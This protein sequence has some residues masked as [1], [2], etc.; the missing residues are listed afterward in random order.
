MRHTYPTAPMTAHIM[1]TSFSSR[2]VRHSQALRRAQRHMQVL[3]LCRLVAAHC[4]SSWSLG[5]LGVVLGVAG[6]ALSGAQARKMTAN[7]CAKAASSSSTYVHGGGR[8]I[9]MFEAARTA[10]PTVAAH[11]SVLYRQVL[12]VYR[13]DLASMLVKCNPSTS[14]PF[15][16][17]MSKPL[18]GIK[19]PYPIPK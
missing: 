4:T 3:G 7:H 16:S 5:G 12:A 18:S 13:I 8:V 6:R 17:P 2:P 9:K 14:G 15:S 1:Q 10:T 11:V 19:D